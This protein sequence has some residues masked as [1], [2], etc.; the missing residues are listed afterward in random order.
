MWFLFNKDLT[1]PSRGP[2]INLSKT[3]SPPPTRILFPLP[4]YNL[5]LHIRIPHTPLLP[6]F[7]HFFAYILPFCLVFLSLFFLFSFPPSLSYFY[8]FL[9]SLFMF[10]SQMT[11]ADIYI[12]RGSRFSNMNTPARSG[13]LTFSPSTVNPS[14]NL[15]TQVVFVTI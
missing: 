2:L 12:C 11:S 15:T 10:R 6:S 7:L 13:A 9:V 14:D 8:L 3:L 1:S 4:H 5:Y